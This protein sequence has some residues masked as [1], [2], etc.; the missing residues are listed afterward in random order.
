MDGAVT[1]RGS[2][3]TM[4]RTAFALAASLAFAG[5]GRD[6]GGAAARR[7]LFVERRDTG[8]DFVHRNGGRGM[9]RLVEING[10]GV[11]LLDY[12]G[13]GDL[14]LFFPQGATLPGD[15]RPALDLRDRLFRNDGHLHFTDVTDAA[16]VSDGGSGLDD[17]SYA[18]VCPDF[19]GDGDP[20][21]LVLNAGHDRFLRN[22][23]GHAGGGPHFVDATAEFGGDSPEWS[24]AAAFVDF[25]RDGDLDL[26]VVNYVKEDLHHRG[27]G[28]LSR[29]EQ[30]RSYCH[31]DEF[32]AADDALFKNDGGRLVDVSK[33][34]GVAGTGGA[35]LGCVLS[36]YDGDGDADLFVADDSTPNLLW[37]NEGGFRFTQAA[38][39]A[40]VAVNGSGVTTAAMGTDFGDIDH[41]GDF[42]LIVANL[43][44]EVNTL[45]RNDGTGH[46]DDRST[47]TG[48]GPPS[49]R[50][51]GFGCE[52][53]DFDLDGDLD[54][55]VVNGHVIDNVQLY[56]PSQTFRQPP[57]FYRNDGSGRFTEIGAEA[58][59][60]FAGQY[61]GRGLA[62]G[63]LDD[64]GDPDVVACQNNGPPFL[65]ENT[66]D[67]AAPWLGLK[68][69]GRG[70]N[71]QAIGALVT[72]E[73]GGMK[74]IEEVRGTSSYGAFHDL[75]LLF[76]LA[77][78]KDAPAKESGVAK[79]TVR[80]PDGKTTTHGPLAAGRYH[81]LREE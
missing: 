42:D 54:N 44:M 10:G 24:T 20:D 51:V 63:D 22:D 62:V 49:L 14:D 31:P 57:S 60:W 70:R 64:D 74:Q 56:E 29:G 32:P 28:S 16:G 47:A 17:Y 53:F 75:R 4:R 50:W 48:L 69:V 18:A 1:R 41:D 52:F 43:A 8:I 2:G 12:D 58:G 25:D 23:G 46:F 59:P 27:C 40:Y 35:G 30:W 77:P 61:V 45:Y 72:V 26:Y 6:G 78:A 3:A 33:E 15:P 66:S 19:D 37:R 39:E 13:D 38:E 5:C 21:L 67:G 80:W 11:A 34:C 7:T 55:M 9:K 71:L 76:G 65:L 81:V 73:A 68:L 36:D 79:V